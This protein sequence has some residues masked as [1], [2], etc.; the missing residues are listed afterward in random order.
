MDT[1]FLITGATGAL[2]QGLL[3]RLLQIYPDSK[4]IVLTRSIPDTQAHPRI[5]FVRFDIRSDDWTLAI[6]SSLAA[7]ISVIL[8][9][10]AD[11]RWNA[12]LDTALDVN[13]RASGRLADWAA[14]HCPRLRRFCYVSTAYVVAPNH[15]DN[16]PD[17]VV[18]NGKNFNNPYEY[19]KSMAEAEVLQRDLPVVIVRPSLIVGDSKSG[20]IQG[21]NGLYTLLRFASQSLVPI[22]AGD[23]A[24]YVD[25]VTVD[26][27]VDSIIWAI[28]P[29][30]DEEGQIVWAISG[31]QAPRVKDLLHICI[32]RL[33]AFR[34]NQ[35]A[36]VLPEPKIVS[37]D[38]YLRLYRPWMEEQMLDSHN[39][40]MKYVDVFT[41]YFNMR[42][43]FRTMPSD[44]IFQSPKWE[45]TL[46]NIVDFWCRAN[47]TLA[48]RK[49]K[50]WGKATTAS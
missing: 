50:T 10:A 18:A 27:V 37:Y 35:G 6:P 17:R 30:R 23:P 13:T 3:P 34:T 32:A 31:A 22:V 48:V 8:H 38:T 25:I 21:F 42:D 40:V 49:L 4:F 43:P 16:A 24:A 47:G 12:P 7:Q 39:R 11:V 28:D 14:A 26:T 19:S 9:L 45:S 2:G 1:H 5:H 44:I 20:Q 33:N 36:K 46:S 15:L 29:N 41:P